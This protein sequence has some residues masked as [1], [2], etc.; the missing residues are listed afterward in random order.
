[1]AEIT[2]KLTSITDISHGSIAPQF[3][4]TP[5]AGEEAK[6]SSSLH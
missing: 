1:M 6:S 3:H 5:E 2:G 4:L